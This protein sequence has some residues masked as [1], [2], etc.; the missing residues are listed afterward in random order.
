MIRGK[1][2]ANILFDIIHRPQD[3][4]PVILQNAGMATG[5]IAG[6]NKTRPNGAHAVR[7]PY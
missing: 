1:L 2:P 6:A 5:D 7:P 4:I 3:Y